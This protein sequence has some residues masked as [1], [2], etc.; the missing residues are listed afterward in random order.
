MKYMRRL[1]N[2]IKEFDKHHGH[3]PTN[4]SMSRFFYEHVKRD[5]I[6]SIA[7]NPFEHKEKDNVFEDQIFGID[8]KVNDFQEEDLHVW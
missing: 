8:I 7:Y 5:H 2:R 3:M 4:I 1:V 6:N